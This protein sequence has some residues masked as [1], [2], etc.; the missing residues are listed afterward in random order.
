MRIIFPVNNAPD[1]LDIFQVTCKLDEDFTAHKHSLVI[2]EDHSIKLIMTVKKTITEDRSWNSQIKNLACSVH[3]NILEG[4]LH[5][6]QVPRDLDFN[7]LYVSIM[8]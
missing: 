5:A 7:L 2:R 1:P 4:R 6:F 8:V 3:N